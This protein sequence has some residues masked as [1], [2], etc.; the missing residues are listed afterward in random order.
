MK[1]SS[2][3]SFCLIGLLTAL[4]VPASATVQILSIKASPAPP[5]KV[6]TT[7]AWTVTASDTNAGPLTFQFWVT[8]PGGAPLMVRDFNVGNLNAS[9]WTAPPFTLLPAAC[10]SMTS[11]GVD[12]F[13][14][15]PV[16]GV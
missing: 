7:M 1:I 15:Q 4:S 3:N 9:P 14:C 5:Q 11:A 12:A 6:G 10:T 16:E 2:T 13:T 8:A